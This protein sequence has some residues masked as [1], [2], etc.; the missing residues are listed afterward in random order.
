MINNSGIPKASK[1]E[2]TVLI[3][4]DKSNDITN[5]INNGLKNPETKTIAPQAKR[6]LD[7]LAL[8]SICSACLFNC[9][10]LKNQNKIIWSLQQVPGI[11]SSNRQLFWEYFYLLFGDFHQ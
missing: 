11:S 7:G 2:S 6:V 5:G 9:I 3:P 8:F 1:P 10:I 4:G